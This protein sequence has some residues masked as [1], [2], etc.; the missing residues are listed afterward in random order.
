MVAP[1]TLALDNAKL[2][3]AARLVMAVNVW[4]VAD[5][6]EFCNAMVNE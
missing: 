3:G 1:L 5:P 6:D 2:V 4:E